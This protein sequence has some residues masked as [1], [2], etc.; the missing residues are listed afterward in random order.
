[1]CLK[2]LEIIAQKL[3][4]LCPSHFLGASA[5]S[6][7]AMFKMTKVVLELIPDPDKYTFFEKGTIGGVS[8][9]SNRYSKVNLIT[10]SKN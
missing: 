4:R 3:H 8:Y 5:L 2:N 1:M 9:I 10:Q 7:N 6:W